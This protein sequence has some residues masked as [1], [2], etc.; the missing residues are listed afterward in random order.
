M[1][2]NHTFQHGKGFGLRPGSWEMLED[3][4]CVCVCVVWVLG[5]LTAKLLPPP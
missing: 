3:C 2:R 5:A 4:V 1:K